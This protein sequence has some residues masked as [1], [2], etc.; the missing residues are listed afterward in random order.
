MESDLKVLEEKIVRLIGLT[1]QL[2]TEN[3]HLRQDLVQAQ[4]A[5]RQLKENMAQAGTRLQA[6]L[7][8]LPEDSL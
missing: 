6:L 5:A 4:D 3:I 2:R 1:Q 8:R 7:E